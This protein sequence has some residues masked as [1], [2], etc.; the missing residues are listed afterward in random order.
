MESFFDLEILQ[1]LWWMI[2]ALVASLFVFMTFVQG[3]QTLLLTVAQGPGEKNL[4][5]NSIGRKW[6]LTF[7]TLVLLGGA[8]FAAFPLF[9]ATSFG[10]AYWLWILLLS[11]FILQAVSFEF[12]RKPGNLF[13]TPGYDFFLFLNGVFGPFLVGVVVASFFTGLDF[14]L[15]DLNRVV[16]Q[17][18]LRGLETLAVPVNLSL[19]ISLVF[20]S[21]VL[22]A[23]YLAGSLEDDRL[24]PR[25]RRAAF[26]NFLFL[27]P[28]LLFFLYRLLT[29]SGYAVDPLTGVVFL[30]EGKYL[31]NLLEFPIFGVGFAGAGLLLVVAGVLSGTFLGRRGL[32]S[33]GPG[34]I[35]LVFALF[36]AVG[37]NNTAFYPSRVDLQSSLTIHNASS[38]RYTLS[39][40]GLI[41]LAV[42]FVLSYIAWVWR[43]MDALP[44]TSE[45][46]A[47]GDDLY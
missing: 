34:T 39:I 14:R 5:A 38:S 23:L 31:E 15:G 26:R 40:M 46:V 11:T 4:I 47:E 24:V 6:E 22:G 17:N 21:R 32:W 13:G 25:L 41:A 30:K 37:F 9:Y 16:W 27:L 8:L 43:Q 28:V 1:H 44:L 35:L 10:G 19:G 3:G 2:V 42:P 7:T 45:E 29:I 20:L 33:A 18:P 36:M 12:R